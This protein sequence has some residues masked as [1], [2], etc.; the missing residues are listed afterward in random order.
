[1]AG[2]PVEPNSPPPAAPDPKAWA[3]GVPSVVSSLEHGLEQMGPVRTARTLRR[4]NQDG[5]FD[6][7]SCAWPDPDP[8]SRHTA[9]FCESGVKA[10]AWEATTRR[11]DRAF[12]AK[13]SVADLQ[14]NSEWWLGQQGRLTEP[15]YKKADGTHYQP[16]TWDQAYEIIVGHLRALPSPDDAAFYTSGRTS[17][18]AA[19]LY[20]LMVRAFGTNNLP[21]CSNM[22]H[23]SSGA[24]LGQQIGIGKGAVTLSSLE[25]AE[26][27]V[28]CGQNPGTNS[29]RM[30]T[31]LETA[32][33][34]GAVIV[35]VNPLPE[36]GLI[37]FKNPQSF[38]GVL[39]HG[40]QIADDFLQLRL[41]GDHAL[42][43]AI[44]HLLLKEEAAHPGTVVD[45]AFVE[46]HTSGYA[47][48][49]AAVGD[50]DWDLTLKA[51]GLGR[52]EIESLARRFIESKA[53]VVTWAMGLTQHV[54]AVA[55]I[56]DIM[57]VLLLQG[58]IGKPGAGPC[59]V[60]GHSNVQ[61]DRTMGIWEKMP[62][63]FLDAL[64]SE[65]AI[66]PPRKPGLDAVRTVQ[67]L[68]D[69]KLRV[70]FAMGGNFAASTPDTPVVHQGLN[71]C[72]LTVQISTKL[73]RSHTVTGKEALILPCL[74]RTDRDRTGH[75]DQ[76]VTVED[77][78]GQVHLSRGTLA[79][80]SGQCRSEVAI[81]A[82]LAA[83]LLPDEAQIPWGPLAQDY[84]LIRDRI[85]RVVPNFELFNS[86][87]R[88][89]GGFLL[90]HGPRDERSFST[91][92]GKA[93]FLTSRVELL[94]VPEGRLLLQTIRSH[95]QFNTTIYGHDDRY[96]GIR[97][98]RK[99]VLVNPIDLHALGFHHG[100][101]VTVVSEFEGQERR[102]EGFRLET[103]PTAR[104]CA[105]AYFPEANA[106]LSADHVARRSNTPV[107]KSLVVRFEPT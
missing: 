98:T 92:D 90:P 29:P 43:R 74:G 66:T 48:Y 82:G 105:A 65:F 27:I 19:F 79:P 1:M 30:L 58:N 71:A 4:I 35:A 78:Q 3:A 20:Q 21:D 97:G 100:D 69:Q 7:P 60:R 31:H 11:V 10:V 17:N 72:D 80:P 77:S 95:D 12:F 70:F 103:Y 39:G 93:Q 96:R 32:K 56:Q 23:E 67:R 86:R 83:R 33:H 87:V 75:G 52:P 14:G 91:S 15:M 49:V 13:H 62:D 51:T 38:G 9:E 61:G 18:E 24:A 84:D 40:T 68:R 88:E 37:R 101:V 16:V 102:A 73:N 2:P 57:N 47:E 46:E 6:C 53:T 5:G 42:F 28:I 85:S 44:G 34:N 107:A 36:A 26:L 64:Q 25:Q 99:V 45:R 54:H 81:I 22:C 89:P 76:S 104:G 94:E 106:L 55:T 59:P 63:A 41:G 8:G 50:L